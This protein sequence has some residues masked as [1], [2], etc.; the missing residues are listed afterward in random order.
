[1]KFGKSFLASFFL[2][3]SRHVNV[4][5]CTAE[6][7]N[8]LLVRMSSLK[9]HERKTMK[10][11]CLFNLKAL[12]KILALSLGLIAFSAKATPIL[13]TS[14]QGS[15][16]GGTSILPMQFLGAKFHLDDSYLITGIGGHVKSDIT[17]DRSIFAAIVPLFG[18]NLLPSDPFLSNAVYAQR[19]LAPYNTIG[20]YPYQVPDTILPTNFV[21]MPGDYGLIFGSGLFGATGTAWMP[22]SGGIQP[23][24]WFFSMNR[25]IGDYFRNMNEQPVRFLVQGE[26]H[27]VP[28]PASIA[29]MSIGL[30]YLF[31]LSR[32]N[33]VD[34]SGP[35]FGRLREVHHL[36]IR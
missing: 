33:G 16:N 20:H 17:Y 18:P 9:K 11:M 31:A 36:R 3:T 32:K 12:F 34:S 27:S 19:F 1:M 6:E 8:C 5:E 21:L 4:D 28:E 23:L 25:Y 7:G 35:K 10:A 22:V 24:P 26:R 2:F 14:P 13:E 30:L 15:S 29:L